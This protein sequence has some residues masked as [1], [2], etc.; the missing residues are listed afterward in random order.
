[1]NLIQNNSAATDALE[2]S[3]GIIDHTAHPRQL[4]VEIFDISETLR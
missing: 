2:E 1:M 4:A 3:F